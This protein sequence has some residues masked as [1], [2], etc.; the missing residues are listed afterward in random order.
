MCVAGAKDRPSYTLGQE[1][2][3]GM[4]DGDGN[5]DEDLF[6]L[7]DQVC[8]LAFAL[9]FAHTEVQL[10]SH[11]LDTARTRRCWAH[12]VYHYKVCQ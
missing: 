2:G 5:G 10:R 4:S 7:F 11:L 12:D 1:D 9:L 8:A 6:R 3:S